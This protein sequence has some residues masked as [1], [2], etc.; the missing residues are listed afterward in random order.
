[1][2]KSTALVA[3]IAL[4]AI[5]GIFLYT[6]H[7]IHEE[8]Q[9]QM[10]LYSSQ[11]G[12]QPQGLSQPNPNS[13][14]QPQSSNLSVP[15]LLSQQEFVLNNL[16]PP[17]TKPSIPLAPPKNPVPVRLVTFKGVLTSIEDNGLEIQTQDQTTQI[18][19]YGN[20]LY[21][22]L[23]PSS[24][25]TEVQAFQKDSSTTEANG[26]QL[27]QTNE[28]TKADLKN[29]QQVIIA[30]SALSDEY[31]ALRVDILPSSWQPGTKI[32]ITGLVS[33]R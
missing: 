15:A 1:M 21:S 32:A 25:H 20:T 28:A 11:L 18:R 2:E 14:S 17:Q 27:Y 6:K 26:A 10:E 5:M 12:A 13:L 19:L 30:A 7:L 3:L 33:A 31:T 16:T 23:S 22:I 29:G 8:V 24:N 9:K 4:I